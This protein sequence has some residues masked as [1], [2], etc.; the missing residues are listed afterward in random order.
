MSL[1]ENLKTTGPHWLEITQVDM[2][3][4]ESPEG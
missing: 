4:R 1:T 2:R 3:V